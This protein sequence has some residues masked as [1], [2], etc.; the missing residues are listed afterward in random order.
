MVLNAVKKNALWFDE[1]DAW[2]GEGGEKSEFQILLCRDCSRS[3]PKKMRRKVRMKRRG[4][5]RVALPPSCSSPLLIY[6]RPFLRKGHANQP[7]DHMDNHP[8]ATTNGQTRRSIHFKS[9]NRSAMTFLPSFLHFPPSSSPP[10]VVVAYYLCV[11]L[12]P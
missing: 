8:L 11:G 2:C 3:G 9:V 10:L 1:S 7:H 4:S 12:L 5:A 6:Q